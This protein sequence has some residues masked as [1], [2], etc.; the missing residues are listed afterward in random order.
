MKNA[1]SFWN[2]DA[3]TVYI[4]SVSDPRHQAFLKFTLTAAITQQG[5]G[6]PPNSFDLLYMLRVASSMFEREATIALIL[7]GQQDEI[8]W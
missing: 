1:E 6:P 8:D 4:H 2:Y 5:E 7:S 3:A